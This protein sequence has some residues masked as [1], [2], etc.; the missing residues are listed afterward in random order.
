MTSPNGCVSWDNW[1]SIGLSL[2]LVYTVTV[3]SSNDDAENYHLMRT[4]YVPGIMLSF[5]H[6]FLTS[7]IHHISTAKKMKGECRWDEWTCPR[8]WSELL[9]RNLHPGLSAPTPGLE[10]SVSTTNRYSFSEDFFHRLRP[11]LTK[12]L[13]R[14][15][16]DMFADPYLRKKHLENLEQFFFF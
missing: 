11:K 15:N 5:L 2:M 4:Y 6:V 13:S 3:V 9:C 8:S 12:E 16:T 10:T 7:I 1:L 14:C